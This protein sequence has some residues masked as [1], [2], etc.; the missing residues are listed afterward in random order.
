MAADRV[1]NV[2]VA[3]TYNCTIRK[4]TPYGDVTTFAGVAKA[5][6]FADGIGRAARFASPTGIATDGGGTLYVAD[7]GNH[8]IRKVTSAGVVTTRAGAVAIAGSEDGGGSAARF[9]LLAALRSTRRQP[10]RD[11][12]NKPRPFERSR[13]GVV[14]T[15]AGDSATR[16]ASKSTTLATSMSRTW[17]R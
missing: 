12:Y 13:D 1:G 14:T 10:L 4:M 6:G 16:L 2:Y 7:T 8:V 17:F 15:V 3:D 9:T 5:P 11:G